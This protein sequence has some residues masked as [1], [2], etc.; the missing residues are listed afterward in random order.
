MEEFTALLCARM[1]EELEPAAR[2]FEGLPT[3]ESPEEVR[4]QTAEALWQSLLF[5]PRG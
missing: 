1:A 3:A 2:E 4:R 5:D